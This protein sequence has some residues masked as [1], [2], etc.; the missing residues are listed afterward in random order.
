MLYILLIALYCIVV[1][2]QQ[3]PEGLPP[4]NGRSFYLD[5]KE[6]ENKK[7]Y[8]ELT[9]GGET[10]KV[11]MATRNEGEIKT[12]LGVETFVKYGSS[13]WLQLYSPTSFEVYS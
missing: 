11:R 3:V 4:T 6:D 5:I 2:C 7:Q 1:K 9:V 13:S 8:V 10:K 12:R